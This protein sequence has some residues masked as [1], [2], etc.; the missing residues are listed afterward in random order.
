MV[1]L[2]LSRDKEALSRNH[3]IRTVYDPC[4]GSGGM[5]TIAKERIRE[6]NPKADVFLFWQE[7]NPE[8]WA[9]SKADLLMTSEAGRDA[10]N[11]KFGSTL[12]NDQLAGQ[13]FDFLL[14]NP[15]YGKD[16]KLDQEKVE[17]EHERGCVGRL[18]RV[19]RG[20]ATARS[21]FSSTC[22]AE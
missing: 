18:A 9:V 11:I 14:T 22:S 4:C 3:I 1:N 6:I 5:L 2:L 12:S 8:T 15:P 17:A 21:S 13:P 10:E 19:Y 20:S 7:V 16:W